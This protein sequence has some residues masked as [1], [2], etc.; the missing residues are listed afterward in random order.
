MVTIQFTSEEGS[1]VTIEAPREKAE[2]LMSKYF[3]NVKFTEKV[4]K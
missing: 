4:E 1:H 3:P 2:K